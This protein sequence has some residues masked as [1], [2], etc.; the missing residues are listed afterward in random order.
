MRR[1]TEA[2]GHGVSADNEP[3]HVTPAFTTGGGGFAFADQVGAWALAGMLR[4]H[5]FPRVGTLSAIRFE[6]KVPRSRLDDMV[7]VGAGS[8][9]GRAF[10]SIKSFDLLATKLAEFVLDAW[11]LMLGD[12][13]DES[14]DYVGFVC[15]AITEPAWT[16]LLELIETVEQEGDPTRMA[17]RIELTGNFNETDRALWA[18]FAC[19]ADLTGDEVDVASSPARLLSRLV[20][21]H[22]D[23]RSAEA[24]AEAVTRAWCEEALATGHVADGDALYDA[25]V[26][27]VNRTRPTGG[28]IDW[29]R[30]ERE[31]GARFALRLRPDAGPDWLVLASH[32]EER[33]GAV[34]DTLGGLHLP[35]ASAREQLAAAAGAPFAYLTGPSGCGKT[36]MA[37]TWMEQT[38]GSKLWLDARDLRDG[39]SEFASR[40][41]LRLALR[42]IIPLG[43]PP[44][45]IVVDGLDRAYGTAAHAATAELTRIAAASARGVEVLVTSQAFG[46][47]LVAAQIADANGSPGE[48]ALM[49]DLDDEDIR[50]TLERWPELRQLVY[51]GELRSVLRRPK[52][53]QVVL[54]AMDDGANT[55]VSQIRS[56]VDIADLWWTRL[57]LGPATQR[58]ARSEL[59][60]GLGAWTAE[61]LT[62]GV[63]A[64]QLGSVGLAAYA[65]AVDPLRAEEILGPDE[66]IYSFAHDLFADWARYR[67]LGAWQEV[68]TRLGDARLPTWHRAIRLYALRAIREA[69]LDGWRAQHDELRDAGRELAADLY[70]DAVLFAAEAETYINELWPRLTD[71]GGALLVRLLNR[72]SHVASVPDPRGALLNDKP[73]FATYLAATWRVPMWLLWP[74]VIRVL[75]AHIDEA[76]DLATLPV[77]RI[78]DQWLRLS[79][80]GYLLRGEAADLALALGAFLDGSRAQRMYFE[81]EQAIKIWEAFLAAGSER[82]DE[83]AAA[84]IAILGTDEED[85]DDDI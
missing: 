9:A 77:A 69:G 38:P 16:S 83:V 45:R 75:H 50:L 59:L 72:F 37:K 19:P 30:A 1:L 5:E 33:L 21:I 24:E 80:T 61:H 35:R 15:G 31:I 41:R 44:V 66:E 20:A 4:G 54:R 67:A 68:K 14:S 17:Q 11:A 49:G 6:E 64:G 58:A 55:A 40:S 74:P 13:F 63:R 56:E 3:R 28:S 12:D 73:E 51:Q 42:E 23:F 71:G 8:V 52:M 78:V 48:T 29:G 57:A 26:T 60:L 70:L 65:G 46:L 43:Q 36:A 76:V 10:L 34:S 53:L 32:T 82:P 2:Y 22:C 7:L 85:L 47:E 81:D 39:L 84:V 27:M 79:P 25:L 62:D 18:S